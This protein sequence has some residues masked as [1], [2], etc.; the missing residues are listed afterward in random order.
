[1]HYM[2]TELYLPSE[3]MEIHGIMSHNMPVYAGG[4]RDNFGSREQFST[5]P[6]TLLGIYGVSDIAERFTTDVS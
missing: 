4:L 6:D 3:A 1:M 2:R 5:T